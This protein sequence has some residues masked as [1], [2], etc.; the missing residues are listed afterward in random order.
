[1]KTLLTLTLCAMA[2]M[3]QPAEGQKKKCLWPDEYDLGDGCEC[4]GPLCPVMSP[5]DE[6]EPSEDGPHACPIAIAKEGADAGP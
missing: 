6:C 3:W 4:V 5:S 1:M 2:V